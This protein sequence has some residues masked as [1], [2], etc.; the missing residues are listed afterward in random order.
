MIWRGV[1]LFPRP[2]QSYPADCRPTVVRVRACVGKFPASPVA[3]LAA[4]SVIGG[5]GGG[6]RTAFYCSPHYL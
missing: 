5:G 3:L 1:C 6:R 2:S 4:S